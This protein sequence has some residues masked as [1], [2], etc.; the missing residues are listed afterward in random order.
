MRFGF[1][2][3]GRSAGRLERLARLTRHAELA[4][5]DLVTALSVTADPDL[6]LTGVL[7]IAEA[8]DSTGLP[9]SCSRASS[10]GR[11]GMPVPLRKTA[12]ASARSTERAKR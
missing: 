6:A 8:L 3:P 11:V 10:T 9:R 5:D 7:G 4:T 12:S 2:D 1:T